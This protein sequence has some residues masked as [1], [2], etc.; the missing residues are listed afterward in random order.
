MLESG[1]PVFDCQIVSLLSENAIYQ[2]YL[3]K[4]SDATNAKLFHLLTD[5]QFKQKQ[6]QSFFDQADRLLSQTFSGIGTPL[7]VENIEGKPACL[8]PSPP[9]MPL[10]HTINGGFSVRQ[11]VEFIQ[12]ISACLS[13]PH[14]AGLWH[15]NLSPETIYLDG[16]LPYLA[17]F[18]LSQLIRLDYRSG[19][20]PRYTSPEQVRG[21]TP[22]VAADSYNLGCIFYH[23]LTGHSPFF[24]SDAFTIA[25]QHIQ[26]EFPQLPEELS[27]LQL[28]LDSMI[29]V[30]PVD[31]R[32]SAELVVQLTHLLTL[33][34]IDQLHLS[35]SPTDPDD[36][37]SF[38][39]V[40]SLPEGENSSSEITA[41]IEARLKEHA[42]DV[43]ELAPAAMTMADEGD[44]A[45][46]LNSVCPPKKTGFWRFLLVLILGIGIGWGLFLQFYQ[47]PPVVSPVVIEPEPQVESHEVLTVDLDRGLR[48]WQ[49][50]DFNGAE[51]E[52]KRIISDH[53]DDP[54]AYNNLAAFYAAQGNY[55]QACD[56]LE[57]ALATDEGYATIYRNLGSVYAEMARGSYG[58][59]LQLGKTRI[60]VSLP[61]FSSQGVVTLRPVEKGSLAVS[62]QKLEKVADLSPLSETGL[63]LAAVTE[64]ADAAAIDPPVSAEP[65]DPLELEVGEESIQVELIVANGNVESKD[66]SGAVEVVTEKE[67]PESVE[68]FMQR[69]AQAWSSQDVDDY[70]SFYGE[71]F[72]PPAGKSRVA[73]EAQRRTRLLA[74]KHIMVSLDGFKLN[75]QEDNRMQVEVIQSYKSDRFADRFKKIFD[76]QQTEQGWSILRERSVGR[77]R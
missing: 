24:G 9:G 55:P 35:P 73:W 75:P 3:V 76:L 42:G 15:G 41:R 8:Y 28:L 31:R 70:L 49:D 77:V 59:A 71:N 34:E 65:Q 61:V 22:G 1:R 72:T 6:Q 40:C 66:E 13:A 50:A 51:T 23:L 53:Q 57:L 27:L 44:V 52:F 11:A 37:S 26:G 47:H 2:S 32:T 63:L 48:L 7:K 33:P 45:D 54:R 74:P 36:K 10:S 64:P 62:E 38:R 43:Q 21:E 4:C 29:E 17:D 69:W 46:S 67:K 5:Q 30:M 39:E 18:S 60:L 20:D 56:Y 14:H 16:D 19:I 68:T 25:K 58:R 12:K